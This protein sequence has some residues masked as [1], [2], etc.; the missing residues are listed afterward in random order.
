MRVPSAAA[1]LLVLAACQAES[2]DATPSSVPAAGVAGDAASSAAPAA[3]GTVVE[4]KAITDERGNRFEP[5]KVEA[6]PGDV[7]R[8]T[9][10]SGVHNI[11][12]LA[13]SNPG[14]QGLPGATEMLQLPGQTVDVPV[15]MQPGNYFFQ[16]DPHAVLGMV[17]HL[18]VED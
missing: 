4:I 8:L 14:A 7:L 5:A 9:L 13:D 3:T 16:C 6:K 10:V 11:H 18:E 17:G 12:F 1:L 15:T 2:R